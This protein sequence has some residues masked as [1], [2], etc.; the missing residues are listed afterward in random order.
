MKLGRP[1]GAVAAF[2]ILFAVPLAGTPVV[3]Q[4][5]LEAARRA[6]FPHGTHI[7]EG[8]EIRRFDTHRLVD[9]PFGPVL[10]S[11]GYIEMGSHATP[12]VIA[13][14]YLRPNGTGFAV[15]RAFPTAV[16]NGSQG[17]MSEWRISRQFTDLPAIYT[18]GGGTWQG[19][20][21]MVAT[22]TELRPEGPVQTAVIPIS[23]ENEGAV[24]TRRARRFEGRIAN[25]RRGGSFDVIFTGSARFTEHYVYR[26]GRFV[27]TTRESR[28]SC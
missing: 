21:C 10:V 17:D 20:T 11:E 14:H 3:A 1:N 27:R 7:A 12:G 6:A 28:A 13:V 16:E 15:R 9:T 24:G 22:L 4:G 25:I 26:G 19:Y 5:G 18:E 2:S 8:E 23:Y